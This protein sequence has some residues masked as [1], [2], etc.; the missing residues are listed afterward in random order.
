MI[1]G[2]RS[3]HNK[4]SQALADSDHIRPAACKT[5]TSRS[6]STSIG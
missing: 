4:L 3:E 5:K 2:N 1:A 6:D